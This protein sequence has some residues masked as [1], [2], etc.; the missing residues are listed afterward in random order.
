MSIEVRSN[1][2]TVARILA[3]RLVDGV[4]E[5][6][7]RSMIEGSVREAQLLFGCALM[8]ALGFTRVRAQPGCAP[9]AEVWRNARGDTASGDLIERVLEW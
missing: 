9:T 7:A 4:N 8:Q 3:S 1:R 2:E 6:S 5:E